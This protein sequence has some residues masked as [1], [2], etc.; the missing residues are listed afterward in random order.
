MKNALN[1][2]LHLHVVSDSPCVSR[3]SLG[4]LTDMFISG[5]DI[6]RA[7]PFAGWQGKALSRAVLAETSI[8]ECHL[9]ADETCHWPQ[10]RSRI[11]DSVQSYRRWIRQHV[12]TETDELTLS[13][14]DADYLD[15]YGELVRGHVIIMTQLQCPL[16]QVS[17]PYAPTLSPY[18]VQQWAA[19]PDAD[20][21][22]ALELMEDYGTHY[23]ESATL[24]SQVTIRFV[25]NR[26]AVEALSAAK[27]LSLEQQAT[28]AG[29][30]V[31]SRLN[32][33]MNLSPES[34]ETALDFMAAAAARVYPP[35]ESLNADWLQS[36]LNNARSV[37]SLRL[38][39]L[40]ALFDDWP[41][42]AKLADR[43]RNTRKWACS[44]LESRGLVTR[45]GAHEPKINDPASFTLPLLS[46]STDSSTVHIRATWNHCTE[47]CRADPLCSAATMCTG[48]C[49][50]ESNCALHR[51][52]EFVNNS[53]NFRYKFFNRKHERYIL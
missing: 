4:F 21:E 7:N 28:S 12:Q 13:T 34:Q 37:L 53:V 52:Q 38:Q 19:V 35:M 33:S 16:V 45:C 3:S 5:Y 48:S 1:E 51:H 42:G 22:S 24:G 44:R 49:I 23:V 46:V 25:L 2:P 40:D 11:I 27:N 8:N 10:V 47:L 9:A 50:E 20:R 36:V 14:S 26:T 32:Q 15:A 31:L 18:F 29:L 39:P 17:Q 6:T 30:Y 41:N 43:W